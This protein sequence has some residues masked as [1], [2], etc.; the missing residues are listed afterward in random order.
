M[1]DVMGHGVEAAVEMSHYRSML[2]VVAGEGDPPDR[3]LRRMD[4]LLSAMGAKRPATCLLG[5]ADP[6][7]R[8]L[9]VRQRRAICRPR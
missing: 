1:G 4:V 6:R 2:R 8:R 7:A 9:L 5:L 3:I